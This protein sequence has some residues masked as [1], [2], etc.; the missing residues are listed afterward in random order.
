[1]GAGGDGVSM[2]ALELEI[3]IEARVSGE[4]ESEAGD[5]HRIVDDDVADMHAVHS[6]D[7]ASVDVFAERAQQ[8]GIGCKADFD[9]SQPILNARNR[10]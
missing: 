1:M 2:V 4:L 8:S 10:R 9:L 7:P 3:T 5:R 6:N